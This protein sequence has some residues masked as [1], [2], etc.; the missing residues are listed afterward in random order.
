[1]AD[2]TVQTHVDTFMRSATASAARDA[3]G[4]QSGATYSTVA[5]MVAAD[6]TNITSGQTVTLTGYYAAGDFGEPLQ[7]IVEASTGGVK[8]HTLNDGRYAN[9]YANEFVLPEWFGCKGDGATDD[10]T[11]LVAALDTELEQELVWKDF[12]KFRGYGWLQNASTDGSF[13]N[14][15]AA[16]TIEWIGSSDSTKALVRASNQ[17]VGTEPTSPIRNAHLNN[18]NLEC[19]NLCGYGLY[20]ARLNNRCSM[21]NILVSR[22]KVWGIAI[23]YDYD[24]TWGPLHARLGEEGGISI[25]TNDDFGGAWSAVNKSVNNNVFERLEATENGQNYTAASPWVE[26]TDKNKGCGILLNLDN[27]NLINQIRAESNRGAGVV[28]YGGNNGSTV[29][30]SYLE[31]NNI[32]ESDAQFSGTTYRYQ[33]IE[34][35]QEGSGADAIKFENMHVTRGASS[36]VE[37][38]F[39]M[40][41][42]TQYSD[43]GEYRDQPPAYRFGAV[44][45]IDGVDSDHNAWAYESISKTG[46]PP[47]NVVGTLPR[48]VI[49]SPYSDA[50]LEKV[51]FVLKGKERDF[52]ALNDAS[53][54]VS[55]TAKTLFSFAVPNPSALTN[56]PMGAIAELYLNYHWTS[57]T[58]SKHGTFVR[59]FLIYITRLKDLATE[60]VI[61]P[62]DCPVQQATSDSVDLSGAA[63]AVPI[64]TTNRPVH[65]LQAGFLYDEAS[66]AD[67]GTTLEIGDPTDA[68]KFFTGTSETSRSLWDLRNQTLLANS[69]SSGVP[70]L[71]TSAGGKTGTGQVRAVVDYITE[72]ANDNFG[73]SEKNN[74]GDKTDEFVYATDLSASISGAT[75]AT[76]TIAIQFSKTWVDASTIYLNSVCQLQDL[77]WINTSTATPGIV[78]FS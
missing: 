8:S 45:D 37:S 54:T 14:N 24:T 39:W 36:S 9:L 65:L 62:A 31:N 40:T 28:I 15:N 63:V 78:K 34:N 20:A 4:I 19:N 6:V 76:Q 66:S 48:S 16:T 26:T 11:N 61:L 64:L 42:G 7:L 77:S 35:S 5:E 52:Q 75:T 68:D 10:H 59:K 25:G 58:V 3:L 49:Y 53:E 47:D 1:M 43:T 74:I 18:V 30:E 67:A 2:V 23:A 29:L 46:F 17:A 27:G 22:A 71:L 21:G 50:T 38:W 72:V 33:L 41:G 55:G 70:L 57:D 13:A 44:N 69:H 51:R 73:Y 32:D 12:Y 60:V 56:K